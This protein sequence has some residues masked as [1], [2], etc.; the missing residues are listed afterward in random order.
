MFLLQKNKNKSAGQ[1]FR[2]A[3]HLWDCFFIRIKTF[4]AFVFVCYNNT[5]LKAN[6]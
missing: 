2:A 6:Y 1:S 5:M 4:I 3:G